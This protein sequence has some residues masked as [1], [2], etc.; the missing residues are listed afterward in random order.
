MLWKE[1]I[2]K[3]ENNI[4]KKKSGV[5]MHYLFHIKSV[6]T[7]TKMYALMWILKNLQLSSFFFIIIIFIIILYLFS[8]E[9]WQSRDYLA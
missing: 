5:S 2:N 8:S 1:G 7:Y 3:L 4:N 6:S 9:R